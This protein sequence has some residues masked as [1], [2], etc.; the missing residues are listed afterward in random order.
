[1]ASNYNLI[2]NTNNDIDLLL[3]KN[4]FSSFHS[5]KNDKKDYNLGLN[6]MRQVHHYNIQ[7][8]YSFNNNE[9]LLKNK[10][11]QGYFIDQNLKNKIQNYK[12]NSINKAKDKLNFPSEKI[13]K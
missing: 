10:K 7:S 12:M 4:F 1:M 11:G 3:K 2:S 6:T 9:T 8:K 13:R 5:G